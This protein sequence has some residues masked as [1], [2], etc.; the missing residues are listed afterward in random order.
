V[1]TEKLRVEYELSVRWI[2]FPLH[3][4][5]PPEGRL[6]EDLFRARRADI[7]E[8]MARLKRVARELGLPLGERKRTYN[9]RFAQELGK[10]AETEGLGDPFHDAIFRAYFV[11]GRNIGDPEELADLADKAGLPREEAAAVLR[12]RRFREAVDADWERSRELDISA[13]PTFVAGGEQLVGAQPYETLSAFV[14]H[15]GARRRKGTEP[16]P[17]PLSA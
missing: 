6:L 11:E 4:E 2:A 8:T 9:S 3:P 12:T 16:H 13:V 1:R 14:E 15:L 5:T 10:W 7:E 17:R